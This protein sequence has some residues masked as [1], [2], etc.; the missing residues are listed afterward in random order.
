M[1]VLK[2]EISSTMYV[3]IRLM[4]LLITLQRVKIYKFIQILTANDLT[5][6]YPCYSDLGSVY[7]MSWN[8]MADCISEELLNNLLCMFQMSK[9]ANSHQIPQKTITSQKW[10][11]KL[12]VFK[13]FKHFNSNINCLLFHIQQM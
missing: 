13:Q 3:L 9:K 8:Q 12:K 11:P 2:R 10:I 7:K 6:K 4:I 1:Q 5:N